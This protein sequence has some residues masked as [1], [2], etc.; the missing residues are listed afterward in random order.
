MTVT[1]RRRLVWGTTAFEV[2]ALAWIFFT[3]SCPARMSLEKLGVV[4]A[5][6]ILPSLRGEARCWAI[7]LT[8]SAVLVVFAALADA[9]IVRRYLHHTPSA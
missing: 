2:G 9:A 5:D 6:R 1:T 7:F 4:P 3:M 8:I